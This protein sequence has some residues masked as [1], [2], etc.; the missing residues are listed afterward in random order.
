[1]SGED[2]EEIQLF[3]RQPAKRRKVRAVAGTDSSAVAEPQAQHQQQQPGA[4][5]EADVATATT[6]PDGEEGGAA[7]DEAAARS[8]GEASTSASFKQLGLTDWLV[9]VCRSL[10]MARPTPVQAACIPQVLAGRDVIGL[11]QTGS[12]KTAAFALPILQTLAK[13]PYGVYALAMT[14][15][16][17]VQTWFFHRTVGQVHNE[18]LIESSTHLHAFPPT[19][20]AFERELAIQIAEQFRALGAGMSLKVSA[21]LKDCGP[22][23]ICRLCSEP[24]LMCTHVVWLQDSVIIGG[25]DMQQQARELARRPHVVIATPGRLKVRIYTK[26]HNHKMGPASSTDLH[27]SWRINTLSLLVS[28]HL[29]RCCT[30]CIPLL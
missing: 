19:C 29:I 20:L 21:G 5:D 28:I 3:A 26:H 15:T 7:L 13:D 23:H 22:V 27:A 24:A 4:H 17:C 6:H 9:S 14:P 8:G 2:G 1:M 16:R 30:A 11:A 18:A 12:G 10:G 25:I